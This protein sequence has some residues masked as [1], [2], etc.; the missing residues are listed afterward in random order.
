M[1]SEDE[2]RMVNVPLKSRRHTVADGKN[3][4]DGGYH[5]VDSEDETRMV[6]VPLKSRRH[7]VA[8]CRH[9]DVRDCVSEDIKIEDLP[10]KSTHLRRRNAL[11]G[12]GLINR[13]GNL[14]S[15]DDR[16]S[17]LQK[18]SELG[19]QTYDE[20]ETHHQNFVD[21]EDEAKMDLI[22]QK[23][24]KLRRYNQREENIKNK[25][26]PLTDKNTVL[27]R[28]TV[29]GYNIDRDDVRDVEDLEFAPR[30][31]IKSRRLPKARHQNGGNDH[32]DNEDNVRIKRFPRKITSIRRH[33]IAE[34]E[35]ENNRDNYLDSE[36]GEGEEED[37]SEKSI[38]LR[39]KKNDLNIADGESA[40]F[41]RA[42]FVEG[43]TSLRKHA[44]SDERYEDRYLD[45]IE[46]SKDNKVKM[47]DTSRRFSK[48]RSKA[49]PRGGQKSYDYDIGDS[50]DESKLERTLRKL[51]R[52]TRKTIAREYSRDNVSD[53]EEDN[54]IPQKSMKLRR[55]RM[56][57]DGQ[58]NYDIA[59]SEG[60]EENSQNVMKLRH[61]AVDSGGIQTVQGYLVD[62]EDGIPRRSAKLKRQTVVV[63]EYETD[64]DI[65]LG[66][67]DTAKMK[68]VI[69]TT[70]KEL[71]DR[72]HIKK[73][74][75]L[76]QPI[77]MECTESRIMDPDDD[78]TL[79]LV[80]KNGFLTI[81]P[82]KP[83]VG[84]QTSKNANQI[85][86]NCNTNLNSIREEETLPDSTC[87][88]DLRTRNT[89]AEERKVSED[90][91]SKVGGMAANSEQLGKEQ[92]VLSNVL[93]RGRHKRGSKVRF[94]LS[95]TEEEEDE[96]HGKDKKMLENQS[97]IEQFEE[98]RGN[99][100]R[101]AVLTNQDMG[102]VQDLVSC[103]SIG[104]NKNAVQQFNVVVAREE[105]HEGQTG[106]S[107]KHT[108]SVSNHNVGCTD[109][110]RHEVVHGSNH[111]LTNTRDLPFKSE[112]NEHTILAEKD[113]ERRKIENS[114]VEVCGLNHDNEASVPFKH[115]VNK[116]RPNA[117]VSE[118][119]NLMPGT[120]RNSGEQTVKP[121]GR[122]QD[123][124]V[125][126]NICENNYRMTLQ[127]RDQRNFPD[128]IQVCGIQPHETNIKEQDVCQHHVKCK[129]C[130]R[131]GMQLRNDTTSCKSENSK[132]PRCFEENRNSRCSQ[133]Q[134]RRT[135][136]DGT[137]D[138]RCKS[139]CEQSDSDLRF[140]HDKHHG[141]KIEKYKGGS[142]ENVQNGRQSD[143]L[144]RGSSTSDDDSD[145]NSNED[146]DY[147][148]YRKH[149]NNQHR[150]TAKE[151]PSKKAE[152][153]GHGDMS[154]NSGRSKTDFSMP[155]K[156]WL[157][158]RVY[159]RP[160]ERRAIYF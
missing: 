12:N 149:H 122:D 18:W 16:Y 79:Y 60:R 114:P 103:Q 150:K 43:S 131:K 129:T 50:E 89:P 6:N 102:I 152:K 15:G 61:S 52:T 4:V 35:Q 83:T 76:E 77:T 158:E 155:R 156:S 54:N 64:G 39:R 78:T 160:H 94:D 138:N 148:R 33:T 71:Q 24:T 132:E 118:T 53:S 146:K 147:E 32:C 55:P 51:F 14:P 41:R 115:D 145:V 98:S 143:K 135:L 100:T 9:K 130:Q 66:N 111:K 25:N 153:K 21:S 105:R 117:G 46:D 96:E 37:I 151:V 140:N 110:S 107:R 23:S 86:N 17:E 22:L 62:R 142:Q 48:L 87:S 28:H 92:S 112:N 99:E 2:T 47:K 74:Q 42:H 49:K 154:K 11:T 119:D 85:Q 58:N 108:V 93:V 56:A 128:H 106:T 29:A 137:K 26:E 91:T 127:N 27:K 82:R 80:P 144:S 120:Q 116:I 40:H 133:C 113:K 141:R 84:G 125:E 5:G 10:P 123:D 136:H 7:T 3:G 124:E 157:Y 72:R 68:M 13:D 159:E 73:D 38:N 75:D 97:S 44:V 1:D 45:D 69:P 34:Y 19:R 8:D 121:Q 95:F 101:L 109:D 81:T 57:S 134:S 67:E 88:S 36:E 126:S 30:K 70:C 139:C 63:D 65:M 59:D 20:Q 104:S 90:Y 31:S